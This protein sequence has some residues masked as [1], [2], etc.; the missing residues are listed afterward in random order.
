MGFVP[1]STVYKLEFEGSYAGLVVR[2]R[3]TKLGLLFDA[4][5]TLANIDATNP[6]PE[7]VA[8]VT[9]QFEIVAEH[10]ISWNIEEEDGT[11]VP[12]TLE[13]LKD[14]EFPLVAA[15]FTQW[16]RVQAEVPRP[17]SR[18]SSSGRPPDMLS[19]PMEVLSPENLSA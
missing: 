7:D 14:Q 8:E 9:K 15:I 4:Q 3:A 16:Q 11:P 17:L 12:A 19:L 5:D 10:L 13:G 18:P 6:R 1:P 2:M